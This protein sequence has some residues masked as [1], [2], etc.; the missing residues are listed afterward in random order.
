MSRYMGGSFIIP[1]HELVVIPQPA[2]AAASKK[3][4]AKPPVPVA[5]EAFFAINKIVGCRRGT[6]GVTLE[7]K[8]PP[9]STPRHATP[10]EALRL[11]LYPLRPH[12]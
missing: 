4:R 6:D 5:R 12:R 10:R 2:T 3:T 7:F 1:I 9:H 8:V 11:P